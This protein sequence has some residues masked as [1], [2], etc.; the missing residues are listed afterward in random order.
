MATEFVFLQ[1]K[2]SWIR[3]QVV[4]QWGKYSMVLHPNAE[5]LEKIRDLQ[6]EGVKN[7][8]GKDD[9]GYFVRL[10]RPSEIKID[11]KIKGL[12]PPEVFGPDGNPLRDVLIGNGSDVTVKME[13]YLHK[14]PAS[15]K[16]AKAMRWLAIKVNELIPFTPEKDFN[17]DETRAVKNFDKQPQQISW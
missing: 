7:V 9:D 4:N 14:V 10:S 17:K 5:S 6:A 1:G 8:I 11:G 16:K 2:G 15:D 12:V 13:V 3:P